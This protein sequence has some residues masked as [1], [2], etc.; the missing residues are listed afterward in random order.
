VVL[1]TSF[2]NLCMLK[3]TYLRFRFWSRDVGAKVLV[4]VLVS[5]PWC[6]GLGFLKDLDNNSGCNTANSASSCQKIQVLYLIAVCIIMSLLNVWLIDCTGW[7]QESRQLATVNHTVAKFITLAYLNFWPRPLTM[8]FSFWR[9]VVV[10]HTDAEKSTWIF[11]MWLCKNKKKKRRV[12]THW[13]DCFRYFP[14]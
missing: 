6:Q 2:W 10:P 14:Q 7:C 8:I 1:R 9:A 11:R 4:L 3:F 13:H 5:W 12:K